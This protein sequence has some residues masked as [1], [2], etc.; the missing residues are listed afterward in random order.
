MIMAEMSI[1]DYTELV[2]KLDLEQAED[3]FSF[4]PDAFDIKKFKSKK[5]AVPDLREDIDSADSNTYYGESPDLEIEIAA[6]H[7]NGIA[8]I[9]GYTE[10]FS[11]LAKGEHYIKKR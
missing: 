10:S 11:N 1:E 8:Y 7:K 2:F 3:L 4:W 5:R 9:A 6:H